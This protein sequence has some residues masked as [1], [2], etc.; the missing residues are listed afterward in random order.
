MPYKETPMPKYFTPT[1][2]MAPTALTGL[3]AACRELGIDPPTRANGVE[4]RL[5]R[6]PTAIDA[7]RAAA[8]EAITAPDVDRWLDDAVQ[9]VQRAQA[10]DQLRA[11]WRQHQDSRGATLHAH[12]LALAA[13]ADQLA[14]RAGAA[15]LVLMKAA[16]RLPA[17]DPL[18]AEAVLSADAGP[19]RQ[20]AIGALRTLAA[21]AQC[22]ITPVTGTL[23]LAVRQLLPI[24]ET[25]DPGARPVEMMTRAP[26]PAGA[27]DIRGS[28]RMFV[29]AVDDR[30]VDAVIIDV[31]AERHPGVRIRLAADS[32]EL[33]E[34]VERLDRALTDRAH[35]DGADAAMRAVAAR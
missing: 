26:I 28:I 15:I 10:G 22:F 1:L 13:V 9:A 2:T 7:A 20:A 11:A 19:D 8:R 35:P 23:T 21:C 24:V 29:R 12:R 6:L 30:G 27:N 3:E 34:R 17:G 18:G 5:R 31:A 14:A 16:G 32:A 25:D 4:A 33:A